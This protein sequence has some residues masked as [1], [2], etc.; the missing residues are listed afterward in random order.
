MAISELQNDQ[1]IVVDMIDPLVSNAA[2]NHT[3][4][5]SR[6]FKKAVS[7]ATADEVGSGGGK[8]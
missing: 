6:L 5:P 8:G 4:V 3:M 7:K 1:S 2:L